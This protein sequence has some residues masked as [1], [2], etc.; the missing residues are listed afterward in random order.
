MIPVTDVKTMRASDAATIA[1]G[2][3]GKE[4]MMRAGKGIFKAYPW[5]GR[6]AIVC[7]V[8]N[9]AG[10]GYVL[11]LC[12]CDAGVP[13]T[14]VLLYDR[15]SDDGRFYYEQCVANGI[16]VIRYAPSFSFDGYE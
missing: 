8:G 10:D 16:E 12:L 15:F 9:N 6:V 11:A 14:L 13:C 7:G 5:R 2:I 1:S 4:L 3:S